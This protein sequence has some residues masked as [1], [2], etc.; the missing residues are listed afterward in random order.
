MRAMMLFSKG[1]YPCW[2]NRENLAKKIYCRE[3]TFEAVKNLGM[4]PNLLHWLSHGCMIDIQISYVHMNFYIILQLSSF[5]LLFQNIREIILKNGFYIIRTKE[6]CLNRE[7]AGQFYKDHEG[8]IYFSFSY[9]KFLLL[10]YSYILA[11]SKQL[12]M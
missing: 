5:Y 10:L 4:D 2:M 3:I 11:S 8:K 7:R 12:Y 6:L 9:A 1:I